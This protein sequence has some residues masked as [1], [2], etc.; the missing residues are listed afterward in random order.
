LE[1]EEV[2]PEALRTEAGF[3]R[4]LELKE[5]FKE[6]LNKIIKLKG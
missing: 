1:P 5:E 2:A 6:N 4:Y 3:A